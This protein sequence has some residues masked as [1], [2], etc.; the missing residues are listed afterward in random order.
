MYFKDLGLIPEILKAAEEAGYETPSPIQE[1]AI[2][3]ILNG[4]DLL[5]CAQTGTGKT[6][7]FAMPILQRLHK[8][9]KIKPH[10]IRAQR[11][12]GLFDLRGG[13]HARAPGRAGGG[14]ARRPL[15]QG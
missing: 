3:P 5:G 13:V 9:G 12:V 10:A 1:K 7:A 6:A 11:F 2:M 8:A 15:R 4:Q 14:A